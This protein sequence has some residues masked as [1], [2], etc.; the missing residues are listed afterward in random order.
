[1]GQAYGS[2]TVTLLPS[3]YPAHDHSAFV[4]PNQAS[5]TLA[6]TPANTRLMCRTPGTSVWVSEPLAANNVT[7]APGMLGAT[8]GGGHD[9]MQPYL[10]LNYAICLS[11]DYFP[12]PAGT[13]GQEARP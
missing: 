10:A 1:L 7:M 8:G 6:K 12:V 13:D 2:A 3:Q 4:L 5:S 11:S 9:N